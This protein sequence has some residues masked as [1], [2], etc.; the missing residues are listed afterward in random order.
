MVC[1]N[2]KGIS[3]VDR[4]RTG[5]A[6]YRLSHLTKIAHM[7]ILFGTL[8]LDRNNRFFGKLTLKAIERLS[9]SKGFGVRAGQAGN[10]R[11]LGGRRACRGEEGFHAGF[12]PS[13]YPLPQRGEG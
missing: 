13:P 11:G 4:R 6:I 2:E 8:R 5:G 9:G 12:D 7:C 1:R 10:W 3:P